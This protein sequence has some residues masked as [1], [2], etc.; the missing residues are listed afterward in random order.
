MA[1]LVAFGQA[2]VVHSARVPK[3]KVAGLH[4]YLYHLTPALFEPLEVLFVEKEE[5]HVLE[6]GRWGI[7]MIIGITLL[8]E[9]L[10]K[11]FGRALH[12]HQAAVTGTIWGKV[13]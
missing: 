4:V 3:N 1:N 5:V 2:G 12:E 9:E 8:G 10:V 7:L 6:L 11:E 13:Q